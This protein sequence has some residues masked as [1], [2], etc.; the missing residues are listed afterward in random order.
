MRSVV[1]QMALLLA[2]YGLPRMAGR[3]LFAMMAADERALTAGEL[4]HR[5][6]VS[7]AS[8][9]GAVRLLGQL[10]MV[11][12]APVPGSRRDVYRLVNDSW[13]EVTLTKLSLFKTLIDLAD[14]GVGAAGGEATTAGAR[15][16]EM[17]DFY[18]FVQERMPQLLDDWTASRAALGR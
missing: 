16:A 3:V 7:P 14:L 6:D 13:Y 15:L 9:S 11:V 5:L 1:E 18:A 17:R 4:A 8:I 10:N 2:D 12:R